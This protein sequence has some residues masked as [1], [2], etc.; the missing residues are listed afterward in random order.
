MRI[1]LIAAAIAALAALSQSGCAVMG[2]QEPLPNPLV[3]PTNDFE[4]VWSKTVAVVD[5][6]FEIQSE[7]RLAHK[8]VT[9]PVQGATLLE[10]WHGDSADF[11]ERLESS[12]QTIRRFAIVTVNPAPG[13]GYAVKVEVYKQLEDLTKPDRQAAGRAAFSDNFPVNR[14]R[15]IVGP[16]PLPNGWI[17]RNRDP[18]LEKIILNRIREALFL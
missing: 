11:Y 15:E 13:G 7:N 1:R 6:Y 3:V 2:L 18:K 9:Q 4:T 16:V 5:D 14:T 10:P 12:L 8:I 17:D